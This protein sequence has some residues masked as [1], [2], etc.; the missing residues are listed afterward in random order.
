MAGQ[1]PPG[2]AHRPIAELHHAAL[3]RSLC[4]PSATFVA[5]RSCAPLLHVNIDQPLYCCFLAPSPTALGRDPIVTIEA[6]VSRRHASPRPRLGIGVV[7][8]AEIELG[9]G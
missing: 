3:F 6:A 5:R 8:Q 9:A 7:Y 1:P 4:P 2:S